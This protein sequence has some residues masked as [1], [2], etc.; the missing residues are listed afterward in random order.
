MDKHRS[1]FNMD[2]CGST[3]INTEEQ[4][5]AQINMDQFGSTRKNTDQ[6]S[7]WMNMDHCGSLRINMDQCKQHGSLWIDTDQHGSMRNNWIG[8]TY[9]STSTK[10]VLYTYQSWPTDV[11]PLFASL[12]PA[13]VCRELT[14]RSVESR[15]ALW[16]A[17]TSV[18]LSLDSSQLPQDFFVQCLHQVCNKYNHISNTERCH[19]TTSA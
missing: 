10:H 8:S 3:W 18:R 7:T 15:W 5:W 19:T 17:P 14:R 9:R 13:L 4:G 16:P 2:Q 6:H 1:T 12:P 11:N